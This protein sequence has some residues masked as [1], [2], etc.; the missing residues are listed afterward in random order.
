MGEIAIDNACLNI[1]P[2]CK[3]AFFI[4][5]VAGVRDYIPY[6]L[7]PV[8]ASNQGARPVYCPAC[9][10]NFNSYKKEINADLD[11]LNKWKNW[12]SPPKGVGE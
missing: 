1:C 12:V 7:T 5:S 9:G 3:N 2:R 11:K 6:G 8:V 10:G 4:I